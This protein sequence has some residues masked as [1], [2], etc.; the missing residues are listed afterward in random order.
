MREMAERSMS[1]RRVITI[2]I[3]DNIALV[4]AFYLIDRTNN[5]DENPNIYAGNLRMQ[6][7]F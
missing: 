2:P 1:L 6:F 7:G 3:N 5:F 4:P